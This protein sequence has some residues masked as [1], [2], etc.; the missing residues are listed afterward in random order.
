MEGR[1]PREGRSR[2]V[3]I[4]LQGCRLETVVVWVR[5]AAAEVVRGA[6]IWGVHLEVGHQYLPSRVGKGRL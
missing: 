5:H 4:H 1:G 6:Q 3:R 2:P